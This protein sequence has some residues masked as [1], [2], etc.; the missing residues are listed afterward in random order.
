MALGTFLGRRWPA[1]IGIT[2]LG[3]NLIDRSV[4]QKIAAKV[5]HQ[6]VLLARMES[7]SS[8]NHLVI[9]AR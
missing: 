2:T 4:P 1:A 9:E 3:L 7:K 8:P 5:E 6:A